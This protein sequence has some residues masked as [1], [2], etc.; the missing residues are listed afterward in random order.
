MRYPA[1]YDNYLTFDL[2]LTWTRVPAK[3]DK[4]YLTAQKWKE[5][6]GNPPK[7]VTVTKTCKISVCGGFPD[8]PSRATVPVFV[9]NSFRVLLVLV[10]SPTP[11]HN[12]PNVFTCSVSQLN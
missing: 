11:V 6:L 5:V 2:A 7:V 1:N 10:Q 8:V 3:Y 9:L 12:Y 4:F